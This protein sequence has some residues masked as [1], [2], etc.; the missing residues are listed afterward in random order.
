MANTKFYFLILFSVIIVAFAILILTVSNGLTSVMKNYTVD[1][2]LP[3]LGAAT[4][5]E[6]D[7]IADKYKQVGRSLLVDDIIINWIEDGEKDPDSVISFMKDV[8]DSNSLFDASIVS[9][10][11]EMFYCTD[12]RIMR[13]DP[14]NKIR[15]GWYYY[16]REQSRKV[17]I[18]SWYYA[19]S[20]TIA[21]W[22][23]IPIFDSDGTFLGVTGGGIDSSLL[24]KLLK[25]YENKWK[26]ELYLFREDGKLVYATDRKQLLTNVKTIDD[27]LNY[28]IFENLQRHKNDSSGVIIRDDERDLL[29]WGGYMPAWKSYF[30]ISRGSD[31]IKEQVY[32]IVRGIIFLEAL[33]TF[34]LVIMTILILRLTYAR[35]IDSIKDSRNITQYLQ[36]II[37]VQ[38]ELVKKVLKDE[39]SDFVKD[40]IKSCLE[41]LQNLSELSDKRLPEGTFLNISDVINEYIILKTP[42][43]TKRD[44]NLVNSNSSSPLLIKTQA[45]IVPSLIVL[46]LDEIIEDSVVP[47]ELFLVTGKSEEYCFIESVY[48][49]KQQNRGERS[50][51]SLIPLFERLNIKA[52]SRQS[53]GNQIIRIEF[54]F[55]TE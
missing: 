55:S 23:N 51:F 32:S 28:N 24:D 38:Q 50:F 11:T 18:D 52:V 36:S 13:L 33:L 43:L 42:E 48:S 7:S 41:S 4:S 54:Y 2:E 22:I 5:A 6:L 35:A 37:F 27:I 8:R 10:I 34:I 40:K 16:Y 15:D 53:G 12:G 46:I 49:P 25:K 26:L 9:D 19:D 44:I 29:L 20:D 30:V 21:I 45:A 47:G 3:L 39:G 14:N 17:I 31:I 1:T